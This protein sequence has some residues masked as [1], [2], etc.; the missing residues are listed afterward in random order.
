MRIRKDNQ[1][2]ADAAAAFRSRLD[3]RVKPVHAVGPD[4]NDLNDRLFESMFKRI[5]RLEEQ[6]DQRKQA[7]QG[8]API[9]AWLATP[10]TLEQ[11]MGNGKGSRGVK[12]LQNAI[13]TYEKTSR[14]NRSER[15][16]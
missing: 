11:D 6:L 7:R 5:E 16:N 13:E 3:S 14:L 2:G 9:N 12:K 8:A 15:L 4:E 1:S 10:P